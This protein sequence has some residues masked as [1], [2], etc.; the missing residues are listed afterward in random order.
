MVA[1][2]DEGVAE[3]GGEVRGLRSTNRYLLNSHGDVKYN[4]EIE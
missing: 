3:M 2:W 4:M 1:R